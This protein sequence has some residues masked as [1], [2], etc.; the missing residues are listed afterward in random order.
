MSE[1]KDFDLLGGLMEERHGTRKDYEAEINELKA[2][3]DRL[4]SERRWIPVSERLPNRD[5]FYLILENVNQVAGYYHWCKQFGWNTD[6]GRIHI[7]TVTHWMP[8][9]TPPEDEL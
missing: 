9:P 3:I 7:Q 1:Y 6:G 4:K 5:G 2:E 8:L